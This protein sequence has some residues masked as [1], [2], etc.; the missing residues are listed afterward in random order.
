[1]ARADPAAEPW[2]DPVALAASAMV[3]VPTS[4]VAARTHRASRVRKRHPRSARLVPMDRVAASEA[5]GERPAT[6]R[7]PVAAPSSSSTT[8]G[9]PP[10]SSR[11]DPRSRR[12][13]RH[14][15][16]PTAIPA[17]RATFR[18]VPGVIARAAPEP[19]LPA[20]S[21]VRGRSRRS[22]ASTPALPELSQ[23]EKLD[24]FGSGVTASRRPLVMAPRTDVMRTRFA[25]GPVDLIFACERLYS[26]RDVVPH[27]LHLIRDRCLRS[28]LA[29]R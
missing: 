10:G 28:A 19:P 3:A 12:C 11:A 16:R 27:A 20:A 5:G 18:S 13:A 6:T 17:R 25:N 9:E 7:I 29:T 8:A 15:H 23:L 22:R 4:V 26:R 2:A 24:Q 21:M 14:H 1:V